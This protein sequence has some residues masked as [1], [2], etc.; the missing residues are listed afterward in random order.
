MHLDTVL[1]SKGQVVK[2]G[3]KIG[4][5][6]NSM[7]ADITMRSPAHL[8]FEILDKYPPGSEPKGGGIQHRLNP[9]EFFGKQGRLVTS[10][11]PQGGPPILGAALVAGAVW[12]LSKRKKS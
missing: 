8:H 6:G 10:I 5:L 11:I 4:T 9:A 2:A 7:F 12:A 3:Q 1:V